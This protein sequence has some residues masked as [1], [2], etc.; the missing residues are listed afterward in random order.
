MGSASWLPYPGPPGHQ[1]GD[2]GRLRILHHHHCSGRK[3]L[4]AVPC[5]CGHPDAP[6]P[7]HWSLGASDERYVDETVLDDEP[8]VHPG[9]IS[10][11]WT[12]SGSKDGANLCRRILLHHP[13]HHHQGDWH[14]PSLH[15][16][17]GQVRPIGASRDDVHHPAH[18]QQRH[19]HHL[20]L[21]LDGGQHH[22]P[23]HLSKRGALG[24]R[25]GCR[26]S[27]AET[28]FVNSFYCYLTVHI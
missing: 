25:Q 20:G 22:R 28:Y 3:V 4:L 2:H 9:W 5:D 12:A 27:A 26:K 21:W 24:H 7:S 14:E 11:A 6:S 10:K 13:Q 19:R 1:R 8:D 16:P 18:H 15:L 23:H 17:L